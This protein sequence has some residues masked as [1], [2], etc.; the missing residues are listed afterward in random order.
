[1]T[2]N[3]SEEKYTASTR[4]E[5]LAEKLR[6]TDPVTRHPLQVA[7]PVDPVIGLAEV[8]AAPASHRGRSGTRVLGAAVTLAVLAGVGVFYSLKTAG[9]GVPAAAAT[10]VICVAAIGWGHHLLRERGGVRTGAPRC[11]EA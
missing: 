9:V 1:M 10:A 5:R 2:T 3:W 8:D 7:D 4:G 11:P 6:R